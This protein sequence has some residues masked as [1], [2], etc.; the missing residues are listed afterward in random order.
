[1]I[2]EFKKFIL[3]GNILQ[4]AVSFIMG[5]A[6]TSIV[7]SL[8]D[9]I[10]NPVISVIL[11]TS[12]LKTLHYVVG[13]GSFK[14][15]EAAKKAGAVVISYGAFIS[16]IITFI[17]TAFVVFLIVKFFNSLEKKKEEEITTKKC[18]ECILDI[19][20]DA[21]RCPHCTSEVATNL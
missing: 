13:G 4:M 20:I 8:V 19:P 21:K 7:K 15:I 1:M 12:N 3:R 14:T 2:N 16:A 9:D 11:P 17:M 18:S 10:L 6:F 5:A